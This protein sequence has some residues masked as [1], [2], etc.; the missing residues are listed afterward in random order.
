MDEV[1]LTSVKVINELYKK[2]KNKTIEDEFS[3]QKL[4]NRS[5]DLFV[6]DEKFRKSVIEYTELHKS[7][8][9]F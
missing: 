8:S 2:F 3:L 7:G 4:V 9:K 6:H 1:K 5:L